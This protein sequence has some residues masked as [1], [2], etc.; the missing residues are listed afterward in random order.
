MAPL[1]GTAWTGDGDGGG[2][3]G[4]SVPYT[5]CD[6]A[7]WMTPQCM[8]HGTGMGSSA[9]A[10]IGGR[11][12]VLLL[13]STFNELTGLCECKGRVTPDP[14]AAVMSHRP[15]LPACCIKDLAATDFGYP[16]G[17]FHDRTVLGFAL[18][19]SL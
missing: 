3:Q 6:G 11:P 9:L 8:G 1:A 19:G 2:S 5:E 18:V 17:N 13:D 7:L 4:C 10:K 14:A 12:V 15:S 16:W